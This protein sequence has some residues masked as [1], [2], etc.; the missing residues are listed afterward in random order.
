MDNC[1]R[2]GLAFVPPV[3]IQS[4]PYL[5]QTL[6]VLTLS[7]TSPG[8][9]VSAVQ[10]FWKQMEKEKLLV[11]SNFF[12]SHSV[13]YPFGEVVVYKLFQ[14]GRVNNLSPLELL[15][16]IWLILL[17]WYT[18]HPAFLLTFESTC[19]EKS[20]KNFFFFFFFFFWGGG[21]CVL[22]GSVVKCLTRNSG[23]LGSR[24]TGSSEFFVGVSLGQTLQSPSLVLVKPRKDINN[25]SCRRD[26]TEI[27]LK[28]A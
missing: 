24:H 15:S 21:R 3:T 7:Q 1:I 26:M 25:V 13:F 9:Y 8:F 28:A 19:Y 4:I 23:V 12:F 11:T 6:S 18:T 17:D 16:V 14:F 22:R 10:D 5:H 20:L 2:H 27:L